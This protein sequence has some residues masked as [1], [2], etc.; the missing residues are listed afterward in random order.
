MAETRKLWQ[1]L[2]AERAQCPVT[3]LE[4]TNTTRVTSHAG[5]K[6][7]LRNTVAFSN[8]FGTL[9]PETE[10]PLADQV[11]AFADPPRHARQRRLLTAALSASRVERLR[12]SMEE[13]VGGLL[14]AIISK[15]SSQFEVISEFALPFPAHT[16][17]ELMGVP[18][19]LRDRFIHYSHLAELDS[20]M[21][22][23]YAKELREWS[24]LIEVL[25]RERRAAGPDASDDLI[26]TMCFAEVDGEHL[27]E[28]EVAQMVVL[29]NEAGNTTTTTLIANAVHALDEFP[30]QKAAFLADIDGLVESVVEETL[31]YEGPIQGLFRRAVCP[32]EVAGYEI[33][34]GEKVFG[35][36]GGANHDPEVYERPDEFVLGRDWRKLPAH[37]GFGHGIHHC[38]GA[39]VARTESIVALSMLYKRLPGLRVTPGFE[40][41]P[42]P[43]Q[44]FCG[45]TEM[46]MSFDK[47]E[48]GA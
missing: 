35:S 27:S 28:R 23:T 45:W 26:T 16:T 17:A 3:K 46:Q 33:P 13:T 29:V 25:V 18:H 21:P 42:V 32:G 22:G 10:L 40:P 9:D 34:A 8:R 43:G 12:S 48:N 11:L 37:M 38:L 47:P 19:E 24:D 2:A 7:L 6:Q 5:V 14:D 31:R 30:E 44:I 41:V 1:E 36:Y 39:N 15:D 20:A 4:G